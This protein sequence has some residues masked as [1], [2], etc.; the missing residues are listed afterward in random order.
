MRQSKRTTYST[1]NFTLFEDD[2]KIHSVNVHVEIR[3]HMSEFTDK[4][5]GTTYGRSNVERLRDALGQAFEDLNT[6]LGEVKQ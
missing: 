6:I 2:G 1:P 4:I 5:Q 3:G